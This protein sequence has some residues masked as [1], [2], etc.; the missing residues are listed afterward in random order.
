MTLLSIIF[1]QVV[2][3]ILYLIE[4]TRDTEERTKADPSPLS[5]L[6]DV[7]PWYQQRPLVPSRLFRES[8]RI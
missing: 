3:C 8:R 2:K 4:D 7:E 6:K 5:E 1:V